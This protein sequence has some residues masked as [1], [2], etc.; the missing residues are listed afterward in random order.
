MSVHLKGSSAPFG[1]TQIDTGGEGSRTQLVRICEE[2]QARDKAL[3]SVWHTRVLAK[4][5]V[6][7]QR[8]P[9]MATAFGRPQT[10]R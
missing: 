8:S 6:K 9:F 1:T 4:E 3:Q 7:E 2:G 10:R 5:I